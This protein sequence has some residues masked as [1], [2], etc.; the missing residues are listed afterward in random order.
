MGVLMPMSTSVIAFAAEHPVFNNF[1]SIFIS[2][3]YVQMGISLAV[4]V[5]FMDFVNNSYWCTKFF[6]VSMYTAYIIQP[7]VITFAQ[8]FWILILKST[9]N[10][11]VGKNDVGKV[12]YSYSDENLVFPGWL[13]VSTVTMIVIWPLSYLIRSI[14]GFSEVL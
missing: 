7:I 10:L 14:P 8:W 5:F 4:T 12:T 3:S 9:N 2:R 1:I 11:E 6:T 13:F